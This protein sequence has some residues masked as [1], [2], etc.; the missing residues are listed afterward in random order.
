MG[1][2]ARYTWV[3]AAQSASCGFAAPTGIRQLGH[4]GLASRP[5]QFPRMGVSWTR[6]VA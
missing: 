4:S 1:A 6:M 5:M 2:V 3:G